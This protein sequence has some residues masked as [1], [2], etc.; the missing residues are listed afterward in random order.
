[1]SRFRVV[2]DPTS[3]AGRGLCA[4][5]FPERIRLDRW[6]YPIVDGE[7]VPLSLLDHALRAESMCPHLAIHV[8]EQEQEVPRPVASPRRR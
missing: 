2:V 6:G 5:L 1:V 7:S 4:E 8:V 3:C